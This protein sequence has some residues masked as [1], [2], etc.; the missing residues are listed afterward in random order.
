MEKDGAAFDLSSTTVKF[1]MRAIG[2][3]A[4]KVDAAASIVS[5]AAGTVRYDWEAAN[6]DTAGLYVGWWELTTGGLTETTGEF[7]LDLRDHDV[8]ATNWCCDVGDIR[9]ALELQHGEDARIS[10]ARELIGPASSAIMEY[11]QRE[12]AP[13][14]GSATRTF[15]VS[16]GSGH[17]SVDLAPYDLRTVSSVQLHPEASSPTTLT[18][19]SDYKLSPLPSKDGTYVRLVLYGGL[20]FDSTLRTRLGAA[21]I[22]V[23]GAWG[24]ATVPVAV[25]RATALT[26]SSWMD[27][28]VHEYGGMGEDMV[29]GLAPSTANGLAIP[30]AAR[31]LV[32]PFR[33][34]AVPV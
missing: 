14:T 10:L 11:T 6:V 25:R 13:A 21:R 17:P 9:I 22:D 19:D 8:A 31:K 33:R 26:V 18:V 30:F 16:F 3:S 15:E 2:D 28:P 34:L 29:D 7:L 32:D 12:F 23:A 27:R 4:L 1:Q 5:A 20:G 24:H